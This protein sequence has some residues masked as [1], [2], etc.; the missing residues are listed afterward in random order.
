[1]VFRL[2]LWAVLFLSC[3]RSTAP[4]AQNTMEDL[5]ISIRTDEAIYNDYT[6]VF[7]DILQHLNKLSGIRASIQIKPD[8]ITADYTFVV[9]EKQGL[10]TDGQS[11][12]IE[13][14]DLVC[15]IGG[16]APSGYAN[17]LYYFLNQ[18]GFRWYMPGEAWTIIPDSLKRKNIPAKT[19]TP[20]FRDRYYFGTGGWGGKK[21]Y[22]PENQVKK[23][24]TVWNRRNRISATYR[25]SGHTGMAFYRKNKAYLDQHP[26]FFCHGKPGQNA[27]IRLNSQAFVDYIVRQKTKDVAWEKYGTIGMDPHDGSGGK[28]DCLDSP[29][30]RFDNYSDKYFWLANE[31]AKEIPK[32]ANTLVD[33][34]AY[35]NHA[36]TP[37]FPLNEKV[38]PIIAPYAF[39]R[40]SPP[41]QYI[42]DWAHFQDGR[43]MGIREYWNITQWSKGLPQFNVYSIPAKL[44]FWRANNINSINIESTWA[45]GP[46]GHAWW[47]FSQYAWDTSQDFEDLYQQFLEDC[48]GAGAD[49]VKRMYDRWSI[50][51]Q[52]TL[53][54][55]L[56][57]SDLEQ[58]RSKTTDERI[59]RRLDE[60]M[61]YVVYMDKY[62]TY[63]DQ[64]TATHY[65]DLIH[66]M[67]GIHPL[68]VLQTDALVRHYIPK[69]TSGTI[70][71]KPRRKED[72]ATLITKSHDQIKKIRYDLSSYTLKNEN[73]IPCEEGD[74][75]Y[76]KY[77]NGK[78]VYKFHVP[79]E[80]EL[81]FHLGT[82]KK[83][84]IALIMDEEKN[85]ID[86]K[87]VVVGQKGELTTKYSITLREGSYYIQ[88]GVYYQFSAL[89]FPKNIVF[90]S[91]SKQYD[92]YQFPVMYVYIPKDVDAIIYQDDHGPG[93]NGKGYWL[94]ESGKKHIAKK[95]APNTYRITVPEANK[96]KVWNLVIAHPS[97]NLLNVPNIYSLN[98]FI[99]ME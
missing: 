96:G 78:N 80:Q 79:Q 43:P 25:N 47:L 86:L 50:N 71:L 32:T 62:Y 61:A 16:Q 52:E 55:G 94:D 65:N 13:A 49:D 64:R 10:P 11:F 29:F 28:D 46:M 44:D 35:N 3:Q 8:R 19:I 76:P 99:T 83:P 2:I 98:C 85:V 27:K 31:V 57:R 74:T 72:L 41:E 39:Q 81:T 45:K 38:F 66:F 12:S 42:R 26:E 60:L 20:D 22:D 1:M 63:M 40:V 15:R 54:A 5:S 69:P 6:D 93:H 75:R 51:Y 14:D 9:T 73:L 37:S 90:T 24:F 77:M 88:F 53:E 17:G 68:G 59:H 58:A 95:I 70:E 23:E 84:I 18:L 91:S 67:E 33:I 56:S 34:Y 30:G 48:F 97:W 7:D 87:E 4:V 89:K 82:T 21:S 36:A 92:N